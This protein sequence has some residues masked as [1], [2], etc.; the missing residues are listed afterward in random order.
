[1]NTKKILVTGST[2]GIGKQTALDLAQIGATMLLHGRNPARGERVVDEIKRATGNDRIEIFIADFSSLND[3][4]SLAEQVRQ[5]Y[6]TLDVL[7]NNAGVYE[8]R[9]RTSEDGLELTFAVNHLA[10]FLLTYLLLD[11]LKKAAPSRIINVSSIAH[12]SSIDFENLQG[13]K[14]YGGYEAYALSKLCNILFTYKLAR[15]LEGSGVTANC[16]HPGTISTKLLKAGWGVGGSPVTQGSVTPVY[17]TTATEL[18][19]VTGKYFMDKKQKKSSR[20]SYD[21][22]ILTYKTRNHRPLPGRTFA[23]P[24]IIYHHQC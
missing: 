4:R 17:L 16:L 5:K 13:E 8:T 22:K 12:A 14:H 23:F 24:T 18:G 1:M 10:P 3:V 7:I 15:L 2:D 11:L 19:G 6:N 20:I 9:H 21:Q